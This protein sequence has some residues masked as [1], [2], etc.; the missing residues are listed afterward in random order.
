MT[1][2]GWAR[3][4]EAALSFE[5]EKP[6]QTDYFW[7]GGNAKRWF[8]I[9]RR[10]SPFIGHPADEVLIHIFESSNF[11]DGEAGAARAANFLAERLN[12]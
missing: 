10:P 11:Q 3:A 2:T 8:V 6:M 12:T 9:R 5:K 4:E 7:A 1:L